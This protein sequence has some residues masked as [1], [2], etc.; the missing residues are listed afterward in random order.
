MKKKKPLNI[1][2][3]DDIQE[4]VMYL[5][6]VLNESVNSIWIDDYIHDELNKLHKLSIDERRLFLVYALLGH[7]IRRTARYFEINRTVITNAINDIK[8]KLK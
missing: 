4:D 3:K 7:N 2:I 1:K 6:Q 8:N 5:E